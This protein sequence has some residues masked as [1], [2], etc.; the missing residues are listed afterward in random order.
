VHFAFLEELVEVGAEVLDGA[1]EVGLVE[2]V[3]GYLDEH[4]LHAVVHHFLQQ[5]ALVAV[6]EVCKGGESVSGAAAS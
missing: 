6:P 2:A 4:C 5:L 3:A 1:A